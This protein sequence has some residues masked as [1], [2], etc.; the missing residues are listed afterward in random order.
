[1]ALTTTE[2][3]FNP[4][5]AQVQPGNYIGLSKPIDSMSGKSA[6]GA[7]LAGAS[8]LLELGIK[9]ADTI[10]KDDIRTDVTKTLDPERDQFTA[11]LEGG[12]RYMQDLATPGAGAAPGANPVSSI[13]GQG[14]GVASDVGDPQSLLPD[15]P[16]L[17]PALK[18]LPGRLD[19]LSQA[20]ASGKLDETDYYG[21]MASLAKDIRSRHPGGIYRD[22]IDAEVAKR[23]GVDPANAYIK[24]MIATINAGLGGK[25]HERQAELAELRKSDQPGS[26][27][28]YRRVATGDASVAESVAWRLPPKVAEGRVKTQEANIRLASAT[29]SLAKEDA[30]RVAYG[31]ASAAVQSEFHSIK[32][33]PGFKTLGELQQI[34]SDV[35]SG[36][37]TIPPEASIQYAY[38]AKAWETRIRAK[39]QAQYDDTSKGP[40]LSSSI[41]GPEEVEKIINASLAPVQFVQKAFAS[42]DKNDMSMAAYVTN[43]MHA[44]QEGASFQ[45]MSQPD[46]RAFVEMGNFL[47]G[48]LGNEA[49]AHMFQTGHMSAFLTAWTNKADQMKMQLMTNPEDLRR[50]GIEPTEQPTSLKGAIMSFND[51][52]KKYGQKLPQAFEKL[53][54]IIDG[55]AGSFIHP[56]TDIETKKRI[57]VS[58][59][60][61]E[62]R[63]MLRQIAPDTF[64]S[65]GKR[66]PGYQNLFFRYTSQDVIKNIKSLNDPGITAMYEDWVKT[67]AQNDMLRRDISNLAELPTAGSQGFV[68]SWNSETKQFAAIPPNTPGAKAYTSPAGIA[69]NPVVQTVA[70]INKALVGL[71]NVSQELHGKQGP[72]VD[73]ELINNLIEGGLDVGKASGIQGLPG[74]LSNALKSAYLAKQIADK[75]EE[76]RKAEV[77]KKYQA[78]Q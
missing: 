27:V 32:G 2:D 61:P 77:K 25:D 24:G 40:S 72:D 51:L 54:N 18:S 57:A 11:A 41:G 56:D 47:K 13:T 50:A 6:L 45:I 21:R 38:L 16:N 70:S 8:N 74:E 43:M 44:S 62:N 75:K 55:P 52:Q 49:I 60:G 69:S 68:L 66:V 30:K 34:A 42:G 5:V 46:I 3:A 37:T 64:D 48:K 14:I 28:M 65:G 1:M 63:G 36:K 12:R 33:L 73:A 67:S 78:P 22:Y 59:F 31:Y 26:D 17:P 4:G 20:N 76:E 10:I 7:A 71:R 35:Q 39:L 15:S 58:V 29:Q 53:V 9:G 23:I 19:V